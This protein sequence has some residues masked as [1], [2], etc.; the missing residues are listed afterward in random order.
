MPRTVGV[1]V[2]DTSGANTLQ[3][4][5]VI[6]AD[7]SAVHT[8]QTVSVQAAEPSDR[9]SQRYLPHTEACPQ[10]INPLRNVMINLK[11]SGP[12][13]VL[14]TLIICI[15]VVAVF[16]AGPNSERALG[17]LG[18]VTGGTVFALASKC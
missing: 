18:I 3:T 7:S 12:A 5:S 13:A 4:A 15:T 1:T 16:G 8:P 17:L 11:A 6:V 2:V 14:C 9:Q 10:M